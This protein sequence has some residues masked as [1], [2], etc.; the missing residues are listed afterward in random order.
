[1]GF[2]LGVFRGRKLGG[3]LGRR[4][5]LSRERYDVLLVTHL[6]F[7]ERGSGSKNR[8]DELYQFLSGGYRVCVFITGSGLGGNAQSS[9]NLSYGSADFFDRFGSLSKKSAGRFVARVLAPLERRFFRAHANGAIDA[10]AADISG[11][12]KTVSSLRPRVIVFEYLH[13][14]PLAIAARSVVGMGVTTL[15]V[16][17]HD[18]Q[19]RRAKDFMAAGIDPGVCLTEAEEAAALGEFDA[20][21][22]ITEEDAGE[23]R[24]LAPG[25]PVI[26]VGHPCDVRV[27]AP[28]AEQSRNGRLNVLYVASGSPN[29]V[30][31][32]AFLKNTWPQVLAQT[33]VPLQLLVVGRVR[34][35]ATEFMQPS[36]E[37]RARAETIDD[38]FKEADIVVNPLVCGSGLKIKNIE[39]LAFGKPLVTTPAGAQGMPERDHGEAFLV[40]TGSDE[41]AAHLVALAQ[42]PIRRRAMSEAARRYIERHY[43]RD[44]VYGAL[45]AYLKSELAEK[46][47]RKGLGSKW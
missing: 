5:G 2:R 47:W 1:M 40:G 41:I 28:G 34:S 13:L 38:L 44:A 46:S 3:S 43:S 18:V 36:V 42:D 19:H 22:A 30:S 9:L 29:R 27:V 33:K 23:F 21:L 17:T 24:V 20:I 37:F 39:A 7:W 4:T 6:S 12:L 31:L 45:R 10:F 8:I 16:D 14:A 15:V 26:T 32:P 35:L 11:F 25:K